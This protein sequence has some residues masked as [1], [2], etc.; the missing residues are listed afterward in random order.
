M[1]LGLLTTRALHK[2]IQ[3]T[4][5]TNYQSKGRN[6]HSLS[7]DRGLWTRRISRVIPRTR[8]AQYPRLSGAP[9][10]CGS[11]RWLMTGYCMWE[12][13]QILQDRQLDPLYGMGIYTVLKICATE[14]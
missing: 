11:G 8:D 13:H 10:R 2:A 4:C 12:G 1:H 6:V 9:K 5:L 3:H 14:F 7:D